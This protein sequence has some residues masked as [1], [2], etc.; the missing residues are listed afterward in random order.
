MIT[1][2]KADILALFEDAKSKSAFVNV[3]APMV[4]YSKLEFR[5]LLRRHNVQLCFTPMITADTFSNSPSARFS[6]FSTNSTDS[7]VIAQFAAKKTVDLLK[8]TEIIAPYVD[9]VDINCGCPQSWAIAKGY[10]CGLLKNPELMSDMVQTLRRN[11]SSKMSI[12]VKIR[13]LNHED[14]KTTVEL[15]RRMESSGVSFITLHGRTPYSKPADPVIHNGIKVVKDSLRIPLIGNGNVKSFEDAREM[16]QKTN[17]DGVMAASGLLTNPSLFDD[18]GMTSLECIQDWVNIASSAKDNLQ[19]NTFHHHLTF[20][21]EKQMKSKTR[22]LFNN[23]TKKEEVFGFLEENFGVKAEDKDCLEEYFDFSS[24]DR[25]MNSRAVERE[26]I[27][28]WDEKKEGKFFKEFMEKEEE[29]EE[30]LG[31]LYE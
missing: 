23:F 15:A 31:F 20:M 11:F 8:A 7:P 30:G 26:K 14:F 29:E 2:E 12:S 18:E 3:A 10:G 21:L 4:R 9:G 28:L 22:V 13:L 19:F 5:S 16:F 24:D 17:C 25:Y 27:Q 6:E 1:R